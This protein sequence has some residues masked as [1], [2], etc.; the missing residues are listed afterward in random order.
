MNR[1]RYA[2]SAGVI[3]AA[4]TALAAVAFDLAQPWRAVIVAGFVLLV[5]GAALLPLLPR[6][7][8]TQRAVVTVIVSAA[9]AAVVSEAL[10]IARLWSAPAVLLALAGISLACCAATPQ[11]MS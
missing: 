11:E 10:A 7:G 5:P 9:A 4:A 8:R 3:V 2:R 1:A 6:L